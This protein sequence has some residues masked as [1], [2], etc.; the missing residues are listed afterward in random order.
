MLPI[1]VTQP[2]IYVTARGDAQSH[3]D[4]LLFKIRSDF[5]KGESSISLEA[6][7]KSDPAFAFDGHR[8]IKATA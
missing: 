5:L 1:G 6:P 4:L 7:L 8:G 2:V 3:G